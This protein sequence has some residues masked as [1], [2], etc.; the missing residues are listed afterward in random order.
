MAGPVVGWKHRTWLM[1][2]M[3]GR[4]RRVTVEGIT[5]VFDDEDPPANALCPNCYA[6]IMALQDG[7]TDPGPGLN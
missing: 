2:V 7:E 3:C 5:H 1:P 6:F 4:C